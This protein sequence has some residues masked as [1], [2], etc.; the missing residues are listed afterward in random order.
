MKKTI[1]DIDVRGKRVLIRVDFNVPL[2]A[3]RKI[4]DDRR[5]RSALPT[6][7]YLADRGGRLIVMSH[8]GRPDE[9]PEQK[10]KYSLKPVADRLG[11]LLGKRVTFV[12]DCVGEKPRQAVATLKDGDVCLLENVRFYEAET[13]KDKNAKKEPD[14]REKKDA[15]ARGLAKLGD[16]YVNDAFGTC[17]R[18]NATMLT[19]PQMM[20]GKPRVVGYLVQKE[21]KFLGEAVRKPQ[22]P[23][24]C[25]LGG[26]KVSDKLGVINSLMEKCD[27]ILVG[28]AMAY[29]FLAAEGHKV[30]KSKLEPDLLDTARELRKKAGDKLMLPVD[31]VVAAEIK[32]GVAT[33][34]C[35]EDI[36][37]GKMGLD[38]GPKTIENY[39]KVIGAAKTVVWNGPMGVFETP[40]FDKGTMA[41]AQALAEATGRGAKTIVG[42][43]DS[44][45]AIDKAGLDEKVTHVSTGGGASLEF[46][47]G[48]D[49]APLEVLDEA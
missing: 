18:D 49:F 1:E 43:G 6:L 7:K 12:D 47:E 22:R 45:A 32:A 41:M 14:L 35:G 36:P 28:G 48:K 3:G 37:D 17:H 2:D 40:P 13:I 10:Q 38:I 29:T 20:Q 11:E 26:A 46:L 25:L 21:L 8:L 33:E 31:S 15:F 34:V 16:A 27:R 30:G 9:E 39:R 19:V 42:G 5:I 4:T 24:V 23:F 44:A